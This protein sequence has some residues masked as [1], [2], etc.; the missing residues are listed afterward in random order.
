MKVFLNFL[1]LREIF[2]KQ[3]FNGFDLKLPTNVLFN[4]SLK[5]LLKLSK[6]LKDIFEKEYKL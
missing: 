1:K 3:N 2:L 6:R 4:S 5:T